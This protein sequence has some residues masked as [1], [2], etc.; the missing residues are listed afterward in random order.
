MPSSRLRSRAGIHG[1]RLFGWVVTRLNRL[2][3]PRRDARQRQGGQGIGRKVASCP[4]SREVFAPHPP[5]PATT[6]AVGGGRERQ[7]GGAWNPGR[8]WISAFVAASREGRAG[9]PRRRRP[10]KRPPREGSSSRASVR[11]GRAR[12]VQGRRRVVRTDARSLVGGD[13]APTRYVLA[14]TR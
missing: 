11:A 5:P 13:E 12:A 1:K 4:Y 7:V 9:R 10:P 8:Y 14:T 3:L 2:A 6:Q